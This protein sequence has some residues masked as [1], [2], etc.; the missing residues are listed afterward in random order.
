MTI[1]TI[2]LFFFAATLL[3]A[4]QDATPPADAY[5]T[6]EAVEVVVSA[7]VTGRLVEFW[8]EE[9]QTLI[10]G[11]PVG[12]I[13]TVQLHLQRRQLL[14]GREG[15]RA[16]GTGIEAQIEVL[17]QQRANAER[18]HRRVQLLV[19]QDAAPGRMLDEV[20]GELAVFER[21][22]R[23]LR[24]NLGPIAAEIRSVEAQV[25][26]LADRMAR[27]RISSPMT[28][29]VLATYVR[30]HELASAGRPLFRIADLEELILRAYVTGDQLAGVR[31][32]QHV[33]VRFDGPPG[34]EEREGIVSWIASEAEFTPRHIQTRNERVNLVYAVKVRVA[35][36]DGKLKVG[37]PG[38]LFLEP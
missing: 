32:G 5:G 24:T 20:E 16:R 33:R 36:P 27:S 4:C 8:I 35:N 6:F 31:P 2:C 30:R 25:E 29:T 11:A 34:S 38:E 18:E 21:Q 23:S 28:G 9:G 3:A 10:A 22:V 19:G 13:D 12:L 7:E 1:R 26:Q 37:M 17:Q 15:A 14:A